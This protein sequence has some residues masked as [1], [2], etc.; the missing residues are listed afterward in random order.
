MY[1]IR[2]GFLEGDQEGG[3]G[4]AEVLQKLIDFCRHQQPKDFT[5]I[6]EYLDYRFDD[7]ANGYNAPL[8][9]HLLTT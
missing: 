4:G 8:I 9:G 2:Q 1:E 3:N 5:T 6:R 7:I